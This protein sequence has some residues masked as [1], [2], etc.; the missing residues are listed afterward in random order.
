MLG[1]TR[2]RKRRNEISRPKMVFVQWAAIKRESGETELKKKKKVYLH[3][4]RPLKKA[5]VQLNDKDK[6]ERVRKRE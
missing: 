5:N 2:S 3:G 4:T 1:G 6:R